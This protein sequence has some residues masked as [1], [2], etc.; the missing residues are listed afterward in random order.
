M[1]HQCSI[2]NGGHTFFDGHASV[3]MMDLLKS[4]AGLI[5]EHKPL[6]NA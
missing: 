3:M 1:Y 5:Q 2:E 4:Q 6:K